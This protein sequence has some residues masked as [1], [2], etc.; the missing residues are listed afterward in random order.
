MSYSHSDDHDGYLS[1][2]RKALEIEVQVQLGQRFSIFQDVDIEAGQDFQ[3]TIEKSLGDVLLFLPILSPS[4]FSP[5]CRRE[6]ESFVKRETS[7]SRRDLIVPIYYVDFD[8]LN[9]D[10]LLRDNA[11]RLEANVKRHQF[12]DWRELREK[13]FSGIAGGT[14]GLIIDGL[15]EARL[16]T[17]AKGFEAFLDDVIRRCGSGTGTNVVLLGRTQIIEECWEYFIEKSVDTGL[18][19]I[20]PFD[21]ESARRYIDAFTDGLDSSHAHE[22]RDVRDKILDILGLAFTDKGHAPDESF[23]SFIGYPPVLD[24][25]A[26]LLKG[27]QNY[28]GIRQHVENSGGSSD[29]EIGTTLA[30]HPVHF[31]PRE[32]TK[33]FTPVC[34]SDY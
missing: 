28:Y 16:K 32:T 30:D 13:P 29:L 25:I 33:D 21:I 7:L 27:N 34:Q 9:N 18:I 26:T 5:Y 8:R 19:T 11:F 1:D 24:A 4:Y 31:A 10:D 15:D 17:T 2:L 23:L 12:F 14:Y 20:A 22:Y 6:L 3:D